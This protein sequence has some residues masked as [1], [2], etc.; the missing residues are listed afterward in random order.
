MK[1][2]TFLICLSVSPFCYAQPTVDNSHHAATAPLPAKNVGQKKH[3]KAFLSPF[4]D[5]LRSKARKL[6]VKKTPALPTLYTV[7]NL[8]TSHTRLCGCGPD[9]VHVKEGE[10]FFFAA[11]LFAESNSDSLSYYA[12]LPDGQPLP[13]WISYQPVDHTFVATSKDFKVGIYPLLFV[14]FNGRER[15]EKTFKVHVESPKVAQGKIKQ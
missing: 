9:V 4:A 10:W 12:T 13:G 5:K 11:P 8:S 7:A 15:R 3:S 14:C 1:T 2:L 6:L